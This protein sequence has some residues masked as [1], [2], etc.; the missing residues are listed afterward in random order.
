MQRLTLV[1]CAYVQGLKYSIQTSKIGIGTSYTEYLL[2]QSTDSRG[3][4]SVLEFS[5]DLTGH[6]IEFQRRLLLLLLGLMA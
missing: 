6:W 1:T 3:S 5:L 2:V 4:Y